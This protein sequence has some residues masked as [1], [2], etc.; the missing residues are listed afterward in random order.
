MT[1]QKIKEEKEKLADKIF[2]LLTSFE[3][4]TGASVTKIKIKT[5]ENSGSS[6]FHS[7]YEVSVKVEI[8]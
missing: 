8:L 2:D 7:V 6:T 4:K 5:E 3:N 1:L